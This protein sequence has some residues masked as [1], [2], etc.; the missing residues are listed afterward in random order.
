MKDTLNGKTVNVR[1]RVVKFTPRI[2]GKNWIHIRDGSGKEG[3]NDL[4]VT[5]KN[6][7][8]VGDLV[9]VSGKIAYDINFGAGYVYKVIIREASVTVE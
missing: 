3:S 7:A 8:S 4:T 5:T 2:M 1:G 6:T 9:L